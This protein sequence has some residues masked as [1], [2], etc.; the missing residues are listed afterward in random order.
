M[1][2][3]NLSIYLGYLISAIALVFGFVLVSGIAFNYVPVQMR[4]MFGVVIML[5]GIYRFILT[6][7]KLRQQSEDEEE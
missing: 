2:L 6:R 3:S 7:T 4:V 1:K 5:V